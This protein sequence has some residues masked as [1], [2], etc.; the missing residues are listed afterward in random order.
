MV[1]KWW[2]GVGI[3]DVSLGSSGESPTC[4]LLLY[5]CPFWGFWL[6]WVFSC[7]FDTCSISLFSDFLFVLCSFIFVFFFFLRWSFTLVAQAGVQ[8]HY[9]GSLQSLPPGFK[10][11]SCLSLTSSWDYRHVPLC[12]ANFVFLVEKGFL[13]VGQCSWTPDLRLSACVGLPKCW[14]Y[15]HEPPHLA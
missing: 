8:W 10:W 2:A 4:T 3:K 12:P 9:L 5:K 7:M 11:F 6:G 15:R 1:I 13:H 14:D